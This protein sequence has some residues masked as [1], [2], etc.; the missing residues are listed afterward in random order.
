MV[1]TM[2]AR[3]EVLGFGWCMR[4]N[5]LLIKTNNFHRVAF[6]L[7]ALL[8]HPHT[9]LPP[10]GTPQKSGQSEGVNAL[11]RGYP[12]KKTGTPKRSP[13]LCIARNNALNGALFR[14]INGLYI[15]RQCV[16]LTP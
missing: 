5:L 8:T 11:I 7:F 12:H 6:S 2:Q 4:G 16:L 1:P 14:A 13:G 15:A 3:S 10:P 9:P